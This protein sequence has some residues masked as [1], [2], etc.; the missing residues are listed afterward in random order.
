MSVYMECGHTSNA[1]GEG[2][3]PVCIVCA[4]TKGDAAHTVAKQPPDLTGRIATCGDRNGEHGAVPSNTGL[5]FFEYRGPGSPWATEQCGALVP[6]RR[7]GSGAVGP[8][9]YFRMVHQPINPATGREGITDHEFIERE[10][11]E[12]D[13]YYCGCRGW[14]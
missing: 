8:C 2:G 1:T 4:M 5:A 12:H 7:D 10:P 14:D 6:L 3:L 9:C 11:H 13:S